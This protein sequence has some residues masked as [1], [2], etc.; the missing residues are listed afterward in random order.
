MGC[1]GG[2]SSSSIFI[3]CLN[4]ILLTGSFGEHR[5]IVGSAE[6]AR[7][8]SELIPTLIANDSQFRLVGHYSASPSSQ[9][10]TCAGKTF[11]IALRYSVSNALTSINVTHLQAVGPIGNH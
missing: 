6:D 2:P 5:V 9:S 8:A 7:A 3:Q 1:D 11:Y 4:S 10:Y